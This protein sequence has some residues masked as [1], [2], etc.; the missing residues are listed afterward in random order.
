[1]SVSP[2]VYRLVGRYG[3]EISAVIVVLAST[4]TLMVDECGRKWG[5][6][7]NGDLGCRRN[8]GSMYVLSLSGLKPPGVSADML[9]ASMAGRPS[10]SAFRLNP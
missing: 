6:A 5:I 1:G 2:G 4:G 8:P 10:Q 9:R 3:S 7:I